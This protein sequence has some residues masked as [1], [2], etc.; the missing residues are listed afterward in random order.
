MH[1]FKNSNL[2]YVVII[3]LTQTLLLLIVAIGL[4][5]NFFEVIAINYLLD[6]LL[7]IAVGTSI[8][9]I[10]IVKQL[11]KIMEIEVNSKIQKMQLNKNRELIESLRSQKHDFL[12][13]LQTIYGMVQLNKQKRIKEYIKSLN[14]NISIINCNQN[15]ISNSILDSIL[16][17]KKRKA[18]KAG[19]EFI[20]YADERI[21]GIKLTLDKIFRIIAN[22]VDNAIDATQEFEGD[23]KIELRGENKRYKYIL[24]VYN[25]GPVIDQGLI[26]QLFESGFSTKGEGR[27][28]GLHIIKSLV[29]QAEGK[30]E[31]KSEEGFGTEFTCVFPKNKDILN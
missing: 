16:M 15:D 22:L 8:L 7:F 23:K 28:Y 29:E 9:S 21:E 26:E 20:Y 11:F 25:S 31:V 2:K 14:Q 10:I 19:I 17:P 3:L 6:F 12:N 18:S 13:H 30:L 24:S 4:K 27:G 5:T 1:K